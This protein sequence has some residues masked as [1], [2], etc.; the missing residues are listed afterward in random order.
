MKK[1]MLLLF[2]I[3]LVVANSCGFPNAEIQTTKIPE[4]TTQEGIYEN[5]VFSFTIP[6]GWGGHFRMENTKTSV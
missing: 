6:E 4:I 5:D 2:G 1:R 3:L